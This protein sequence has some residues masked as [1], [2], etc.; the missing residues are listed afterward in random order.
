M[1]KS[2]FKFKQ[3]YA[4]KMDL[5][6]I[7]DKK[8]SFVVPVYKTEP[9]LKK[10]LESLLNQDYKN[11]E[12]V[13]ILDGE[14]QEARDIVDS[15]KD[16]RIVKIEAIEHGGAPKA[17][18]E[19]YKYTT[20]DYVSFWDSD[21]Y[22]YPGMARM[23]VKVFDIQKCDFV[24][25]GYRFSDKSFM[26]SEFFDPYILTC[27]NYI[28]TMFP[29][30]REIF[31]GFDEN[32][33]SLQDWDM[34]LTISERGYKGYMLEGAAFETEIREGISSKGCTPE[35]WLERYNK[36]RN[37]HN[38]KDR[39]ICF[40]SIVNPFRAKDMAK[41]Y[42]QDF[43][44]S[45]GYHPNEYKMIY[46]IGLYP[47][48]A[49][50]QTQAFQNAP[51]DCKRIIHWLGE[52]IEQWLMQPYRGVKAIIK[53]LQQ[54]VHKHYVEN[55]TAQMLLKELDIDAEVMALPM[56]YM[57]VEKA[58]TFKVYY[59]FDSGTKPYIDEIIKACPDIEFSNNELDNLKDYA[60]FF[61]LTNS[62]LPSENLKR[63]IASGRS[64]VTNY[65]LPYAGY[66][67][68]E[69]EK[70]IRK[71]R[72]CKKDFKN[73]VINQKAIDYYKK[74]IDTE[75]FKKEVVDSISK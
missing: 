30:K 70:L 71:L 62:A 41:I 47:D 20:G 64:A 19:G 13:V 63:F 23:W 51:K 66:V 32:L 48:S 73:G 65:K 69:R 7:Q 8:V 33:K 5:E 68:P 53:A 58:P 22:A 12:I 43:S 17:R 18:N 60:C 39:N 2:K 28:A 75:A 55:E 52:D 44:H 61:S 31:P 3:D 16:K 57:E 29:M 36:V 6:V 27:N 34:W 56:K 35:E 45:P 74:L 67:E 59:E 10:S 26:Q 37:K 1:A 21:C 49:E 42:S 4:S 24:Y 25:S 14:S 38:I 11:I 15:L 40:T 72:E 9:Y 54:T 50:Q 46:A